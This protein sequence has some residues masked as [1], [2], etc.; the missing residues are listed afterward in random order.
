MILRSRSR[1]LVQAVSATT[2]GGAPDLSDIAKD[3]T[4]NR[5]PLF[6]VES[7][8]LIELTARLVNAKVS[9]A[10]QEVRCL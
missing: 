4:G 3:G 8:V 7:K 2:A 9:A 1:I 5:V 6:R 10:Y